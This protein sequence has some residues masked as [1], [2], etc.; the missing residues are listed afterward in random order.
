MS[1]VAIGPSFWRATAQGPVG[2]ADSLASPVDLRNLEGGRRNIFCDNV[3]MCGEA[4][5]T[6]CCQRRVENTLHWAIFEFLQVV[7]PCRF[8]YFVWYS[9][10]V[11]RRVMS[12]QRRTISSG[13][14]R[15]LATG[16]S[17][18]CLLTIL[19]RM[20]RNSLRNNAY[21]FQRKHH[22]CREGQFRRVGS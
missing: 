20:R 4:N 22:V 19:C 8:T 14:S 12:R 15:A 11:S 16:N 21:N 1:S 17:H 3:A 18:R 5:K 7:H 13:Q 9:F 2:R 10:L 6:A